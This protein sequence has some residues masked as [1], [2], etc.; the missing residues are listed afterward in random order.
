MFA[1]ITLHALHLQAEGRASL[2]DLLLVNSL[3]SN[4]VGPAVSTI[5]A[6]LAL[7]L[8]VA[9]AAG[10][11]ANL[12]TELFLHRVRAGLCSRFYARGFIIVAGVGAWG[13]DMEDRLHPKGSKRTVC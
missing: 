4:V 13:E 6:L 9:R 3:T 2:L 12:V 10:R 1:Q 7:I 8:E 5:A 11:L